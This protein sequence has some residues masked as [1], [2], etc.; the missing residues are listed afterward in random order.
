M[1]NCRV[2]MGSVLAAHVLGIEDKF[3]NQAYLDFCD[4]WAYD[5]NMWGVYGE[6]ADGKGQSAK[7]DAEGFGGSTT[8]NEGVDG[9]DARGFIQNMWY[10]YRDTKPALTSPSG[11]S[12]GATTADL[13]VT[14][15]LG[16][17][18]LHYVVTL[19]STTPISW[20]VVG[21]K[22]S[23]GTAGVK[24][25]RVWVEATGEQTI[26]ETGLTGVPHYVHW[27]QVTPNVGFSDVVSSAAFTPTA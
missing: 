5:D 20:Q 4:R 1:L 15:D 27:C 6:W 10:T 19:T 23:A 18:Y 21:G 11:T 8:S 14:T 25:G 2:N 12:T 16:E 26:P 13:K 17:G 3:Y 22:N 9:G 7:R 24:S